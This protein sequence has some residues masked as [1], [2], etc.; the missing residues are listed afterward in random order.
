MKLL[1]D[2]GKLEECKLSLLED[3]FMEVHFYSDR[4]GSHKFI[5]RDYFESLKE[6][7]RFLNSNACDIL[8]AGSKK[9]IVVSGMSRQ[10]SSGRVAYLIDETTM[11]SDRNNTIDIFEE[12]DI[13]N[14]STLDEQ[15]A[16]FKKWSVSFLDPKK[17]KPAPDE[18]E[19]AK[20]NP[21]GMVHRIDDRFLDV[22]PFPSHAVVGS[23]SVDA[24]GK[25]DGDIVL[26]PEFVEKLAGNQ[27]RRG[28]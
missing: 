12:I 16:F 28:R 9:N 25:I 26:N 15:E 8:C 17:I 14:L 27:V 21:G 10:M 3:D 18:I 19:E 13:D 4:F 23:W 11:R 7:R 2:N 1:F 22:K 20:N 6:L 24:A 5:S